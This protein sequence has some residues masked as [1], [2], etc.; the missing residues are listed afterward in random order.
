[1]AEPVDKSWKKRDLS[2]VP[3]EEL[4]RIAGILMCNRTLQS[5]PREVEE[6]MDEKI[7]TLET[8]IAVRKGE[9]LA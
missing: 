6:D 2:S 7:A 3:L 1:M 9:V 5:Y 4:Y 8:E